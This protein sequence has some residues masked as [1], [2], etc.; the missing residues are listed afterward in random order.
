MSQAFL[1]YKISSGTEF[2]ENNITR[3][4]KGITTRFGTDTLAI[5]FKYN[6]KSESLVFAIEEER[7]NSKDGKVFCVL[8]EN[9]PALRVKTQ[10][11]GYITGTLAT[12]RLE[13]FLMPINTTTFRGKMPYGN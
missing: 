7:R 2:K 8:V 1:N 3:L 12:N 13:V 9:N 4:Y 6:K 10:V 11:S 5:V